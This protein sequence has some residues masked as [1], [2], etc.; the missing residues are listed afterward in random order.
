M[1]KKALTTWITFLLL[2]MTGSS[3]LA[4]DKKCNCKKNVPLLSINVKPKLKYPPLKTGFLVDLDPEGRDAFFYLG[5][6]I[7]DWELYGQNFSFDAGLASSRA[8]VGIGWGAF[9]D[10]AVGPFIWG[11]YNVKKN[12]SAFGFG[13]TVLKL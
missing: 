2:A 10:G 5:L 13:F 8:L 3:A 1:F 9:Y 12:A 6:E 11:G 4:E 7:F